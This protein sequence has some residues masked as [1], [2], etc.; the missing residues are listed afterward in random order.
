MPCAYEPITIEKAKQ[1]ITENQK[2]LF[3]NYWQNSKSV[4]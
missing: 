1:I 2:N 3:K 4:L